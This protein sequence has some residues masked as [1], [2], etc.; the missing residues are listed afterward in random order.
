M[1]CSNHGNDGQANPYPADRR[2]WPRALGEVT[3][4]VL[5]DEDGTSRTA[6]VVDESQIGLGLV[7]DHEATFSTEQEVQIDY[8]GERM[9]AVVRH[10]T[11]ESGNRLR[12][13]LEWGCGDDRLSGADDLLRELADF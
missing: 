3:Q 5:R 10:V 1:A 9:F 6:D 11:P 2:I 13:G 7:V 8:A 12:L 4:V